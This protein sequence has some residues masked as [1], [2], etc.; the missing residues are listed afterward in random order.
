MSS[1]PLLEDVPSS[2]ARCRVCHVQGDG[3]H[4]DP[5]LEPCLCD[6][7]VRCVHRGCLNKWRA[8]GVGKLRRAVACE[9]CGFEYRYVLQHLSR[10]EAVHSLIHNGASRAAPAVILLGLASCATSSIKIGAVVASAALGIWALFDSGRCCFSKVGGLRGIWRA[11]ALGKATW[12][13]SVAFTSQQ[14]GAKDHA[15]AL[16][17][18]EAANQAEA[19]AAAAAAT[20]EAEATSQA[21][22]ANARSDAEPTNSEAQ[23]TAWCCCYCGIACCVELSCFLLIPPSLSAVWWCLHQTLGVQS[24]F[25]LLDGLAAIGVVYS[26]ASCIFLLAAALWQPPLSACLDADGFPVVR[27]LMLEERELASKLNNP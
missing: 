24:L 22:A 18:A 5:L 19:A 17:Q 10:K 21:D 11:S 23:G 26:S 1:L 8:K 25:I 3:Q 12:R 13:L 4:G 7:S 16:A 14:P 15:E 2:D 20:S 9:L 27:S 6:G